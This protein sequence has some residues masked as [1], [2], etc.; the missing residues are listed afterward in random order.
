M[1]DQRHGHQG[2]P[3]FHQ[4]DPALPGGGGRHRVTRFAR[5]AVVVVIL[6][7][8]AGLTRTWLVRRADAEALARRAEAQS[9]LPVRVVA[10][11]EGKRDGRLTLPGTL[12]GITEAQVYARA[13]G[14][15]QAWHK[16][17]GDPVRKGEVLATLEVPEINKQVEEATASF[18]LARSNLERWRRLRAQDAVSQ[19][20]LDEKSAAYQQ[21][22]AVL[23][24]LKDQQSFGT[25]V[26]PFDGIVTRRLVE[27]GSLINGSVG[28]SAGS[29]QALFNVARVDTLR[30]YVYVPQEQAARIKVGGEAEILRP[31]TPREGVVARVT[32]T[33]GAIDPATRTLQ[34]EV[35]VNNADRKLL[36][37]AYVDVGFKLPA[38]GRLVIPT[39]TLLFGSAG[40]RVA[41]V[42]GLTGEIPASPEA[43]A[44]APVAT[45]RLQGV[46]LGV[47][48]GREVE[49][50]SGVGAG[51]LLIMNPPDSLTDG[52]TVRVVAKGSGKPDG[53]KAPGA[54]AGEGKR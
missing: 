38:G 17:I 54:A 36:P 3:D 11:D 41:T 33:A 35:Q 8:L 16:D 42:E 9:T 49:V 45:V 26:A 6:L 44:S 21:S 13:S 20:E 22:E 34:V 47:D 28:G 46:S 32:R 2:L 31:E 25:V 18:E 52:Q 12:Q 51:T 5:G 43:A 10:A 37:G 14:Y 30:V 39:G 40:P 1:T 53:A 48:Y 7:L 27:Q 23:K 4:H 15:V 50:R 19:Q 29:G 24:R